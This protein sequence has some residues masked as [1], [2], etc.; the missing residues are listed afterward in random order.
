MLVKRVLKIKSNVVRNTIC[1]GFDQ[2]GFVRMFD[3]FG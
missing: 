2:V 1:D 3:Y